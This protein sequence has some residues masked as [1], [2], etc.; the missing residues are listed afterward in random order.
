LRPDFRVYLITDRK[1]VPDLV[2]S[3]EYALRGGVRAIQLREKDLS[4]RELLGLAYKL[5]ELTQR[6]GARLFINDRVDVAIAVG[7]D[8]VHLTTTSM[9]TYSVKRTWGG[10]IVGVSCHNEAEALE[11]EKEGADFITLGPIYETPSKIKYGPPLGLDIVRQVRAKTDIPIFAIGGVR[12]ENIE[13]VLR[14]GA[15]GVALISGIFSSRDIRKTT[16]Q[17]VRMIR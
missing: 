2:S 13:E 8:G 4:I 16:E 15:Y 7:A 14:E 3:V 17:Y 5:R 12:L 11:A 10:L 9:P 6:Y 1:I